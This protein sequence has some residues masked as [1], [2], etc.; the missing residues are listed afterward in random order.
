M[1]IPMRTHQT[2]ISQRGLTGHRHMYLTGFGYT[3]FIKEHVHR[4]LFIDEHVHQKLFIDVHVHQ[5]LFIE[6]HVHQKPFIKEQ[7]KTNFHYHK[8]LLQPAG[9]GALCRACVST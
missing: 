9:A 4:K 3:M 7:L 6:E 1:Y 5:K 2:Y 8:Y